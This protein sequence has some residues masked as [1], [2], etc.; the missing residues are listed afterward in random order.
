MSGRE[1]M[2]PAISAVWEL[3]TNY[4]AS[5]VFCTAT[6]PNLEKF[7]PPGTPVMELAPNPQ[8]LF[9]FYKRV[10]VKNLGTLTDADLADRLNGH[11]QVL[12]IVNTR[13][14]ASGLFQMLKGE[15][16]YHLST[17]L[18][19]AHRK[20]KIDEIRTRLENKQPCRVVS[21]T[22]MEAGIDL[23]FPVGYRALTGLD[24]I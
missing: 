14:H 3:V 8:D 4:G 17:L 18:C 1:Y 23:D 2:K 19:P 24:S 9:D 5:A 13:R 15:G 11:D 12:C 21:T 10:E 7:L 22:V 6:Q 16:N 20:Q